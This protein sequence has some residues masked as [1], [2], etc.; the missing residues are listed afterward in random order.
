MNKTMLLGATCALSLTLGVPAKAQENT[1]YFPL[2]V[3]RTGPYAS[4]GAPNFSGMIDYFNLV[5]M[6]G[7][8]N[9]VKI[10]WKECETAYTVERGIECYHRL[11]DGQPAVM[12]DSHSTGIMD[13]LLEQTTKDKI[14]QVQNGGGSMVAQDGEVMPYEFVVGFSYPDEAYIIVSYF[15]Q[16]LGG[17]DKLK[18][19]KIVTLYHGSPYGR[20]NLGLLDDLAKKYGFQN[21]KIEVPDPGAEQ[22]SQWLQ[23]RRIKPDFVFLRG[24]GIMNPVAIETAYRTGYPVNKIV[25][26]LWAASEEDVLPAGAAADGYRAMVINPTGTDQPVTHEIV[27]KLY[28]TR[29]GNLQDKSRLGSLYWNMGVQGGIERVEAYRIAQA[30]F[31]NKVMSRT[32][33]RWGIENLVIDKKRREALGAPDMLPVHLSCTD[34]MGGHKARIEQ[35]DA[36]AK[37]WHIVSDW[38]APDVREATAYT[39]KLAEK[40]RKDHNITRR[41]CADPKQRNDWDL[42][43]SDLADEAAAKKAASR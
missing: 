4:G 35:W 2:A 11:V 14:S 40:Y 15:G 27:E 29:E 9:G 12:F 32:E 17:M 8:I 41:N 24:W 43:A 5:N 37:K 34:H 13:A 1:A 38:L 21:I 19:K 25:G 20:V 7:G 31:G 42:T 28:K 26:N 6:H 16:L 10:V 30:R 33:F 39:L 36:K 18:G 23:I 3:Y 22:Q